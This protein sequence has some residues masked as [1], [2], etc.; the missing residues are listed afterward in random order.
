MSYEFIC[1]LTRDTIIYETFE[2]QGKYNNIVLDYVKTNLGQLSSTREKL[3]WV[4]IQIH[5]F[6]KIIEQQ[7]EIINSGGDRATVEIS[8]IV[9]I[10]MVNT[11]FFLENK[12][13]EFRRL[14]GENKTE[15][16]KNKIC[17]DDKIPQR[18]N[19]RKLFTAGEIGTL[20]RLLKDQN[21]IYVD[22][23]NKINTKSDLVKIMH[24]LTGSKIKSLDNSFPMNAPIDKDHA[25]N[26]KDK[27]K[28]LIGKIDEL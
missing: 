22:K 1:P 4:E 16:D 2:D 7:N 11:R 14:I 5:T 21:Y 19:D 26:L 27:L 25:K 9:L 3:D 18:G 12:I 6:D 24:L 28:R 17:F 8:K 13:D 10:A 20:F 15:E 23:D